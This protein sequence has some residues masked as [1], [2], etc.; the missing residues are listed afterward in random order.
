[1]TSIALFQISESFM[2]AEFAVMDGHSVS[3][4]FIVYL[5]FYFGVF[6]R[7]WLLGIC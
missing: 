5:S 4:F 3:Y 7:G 1:M 2:I 6:L